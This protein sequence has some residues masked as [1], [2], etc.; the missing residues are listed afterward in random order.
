MSAIQNEFEASLESAAHME[1]DQ[2]E[3]SELHLER[4]SLVLQFL[5][6]TLSLQHLQHLRDKLELLKKSSFYLEIEPKQV[7]VR[8]QNQETYHTDIFQLINPIQLLKMKKVGKSQTQIQ[9]SLLAELLEELQRGREELSSYAETRDTPTFLSQ[10]D[11]IMQRMSQLSEFLEELLSLQTPG[12]L[13][14]KHPLLLPFEAQRWGAALPAIGLSLSTK[15]PLLFDREKSFAGQDWA[16][17]QWSADKREPLAE[18]YEL[19]VTLLTSGGPGEPG[20]R[21]LQLVPSS[22]CLVRGLQPGRGYEFTVRR[23][24]AGTLVFQS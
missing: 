18:Q 22:T 5:H 14:M 4:R 9:L 16:K 8:D 12:Q 17:L 13:H 11:L 7:V 3:A 19:H 21:R 23:S 2:D 10:W 1:E 20:Y 24:D 6:S 15:P